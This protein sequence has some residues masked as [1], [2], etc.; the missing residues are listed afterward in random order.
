MRIE[1]LRLEGEYGYPMT[2]GGVR[3]WERATNPPRRVIVTDADYVRAC[4]RILRAR[5]MEYVPRVDFRL[6][7][8]GRNVVPPIAW[9]GAENKL[10]A[11]LDYWNATA[12]KP[13]VVGSAHN[14]PPSATY[15]AFRAGIPSWV[16]RHVDCRPRDRATGVV[17]PGR[18]RVGKRR[19]RRLCDEARCLARTSVR[20][21]LVLTSSAAR[22]LG[23]VS[24]EMQRAALEW[25]AARVEFAWAAPVTSR[26]LP[27]DVMAEVQAGGRRAA[28]VHSRGQR[29]MALLS[30]LGVSRVAEL[31]AFPAVNEEVGLRLLEGRTPREIA[32]SFGVELSRREAHAWCQQGADDGVQR[33]LAGHLGVA[34]HRSEAVIRWLARQPNGEQELMERRTE[35]VGEREIRYQ[36]IERFD[37]IS[38]Q[39]VANNPSVVGAF[40]RAAE[41]WSEAQRA[42]ASL[43][44]RKLYQPPSWPIYRAMR[45]LVTPAE[46]AREGSELQHCVGSYAP[47]VEHGDAW[48]LSISTSRGRSTV[49]IHPRSLHVGQHRGHANGPPPAQHV[50]LLGKLMEKVK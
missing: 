23:R 31:T 14:M 7:A 13:N 43:D 24:P 36:L 29:R 49:E 27:W 12:I 6:M 33:W 19:F 32:A 21:E 26:D 48:I 8:V 25:L 37:E 15:W 18:P 4:R 40:R 35:R 3:A 44:H 30:S 28:V 20:Q 17:R 16:A 2:V 38:P 47:M 11:F 1:E 22:A 9:V 39:D 10:G 41:R 50:K 34:Y 42:R 46:L 45:W 5:G